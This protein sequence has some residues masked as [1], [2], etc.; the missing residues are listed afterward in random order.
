M[1]EYPR[2]TPDGEQMDF[3]EVMNINDDG[4]IQSQRVYWGWRGVKVMRDDDYHREE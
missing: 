3:A 1:W 2:D 4:L